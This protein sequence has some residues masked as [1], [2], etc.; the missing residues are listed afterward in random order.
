MVEVADFI[1]APVGP[2]DAARGRR[3]VVRGPLPSTVPA[4]QGWDLADE[5]PGRIDLGGEREA[6]A[7]RRPGQCNRPHRARPGG[8]LGR[9]RRLTGPRGSSRARSSS[10]G[11]RRM[12]ATVEP[13]GERRGHRSRTRPEVSGTR[14]AP[15]PSSAM[16]HRCAT[17]RSPRTDRRPTTATR[18]SAERSCSS[19]TTWRRM[20]SGVNGRR[21]IADSVATPGAGSLVASLRGT[22]RIATL[23]RDAHRS[24]PRLARGRRTRSPTG[25][26]VVALESTLISHG[27][28]Y[29]QNVEVATASEAAVRERGAVPATVALNDGRLLVGLSTPRRSRRSRRR[30]PGRCARSRGPTWRRAIA[31]GGWGATTVAATMIAAEAAGIRVFATGGIGGVHRGALGGRVPAPP[32][33]FDISADLDELARTPVAVVC[34]GPKAILD[35]PRDPRV[36]RDAR[37]AGRVRG[38]RRGPRVL[39]AV[40]GHPGARHVPDLA[41]AAVIPRP[42]GHG[43][44][45][46]VLVCNP[47]PADAASPM[48]SRA[49]RSSR[50][51]A[52][53]TRPGSAGRR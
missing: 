6:R 34:A 44:G 17:Y 52:R 30:P 24:T 49:A 15:P 31:S 9:G 10:S 51:S 5:E 37:R 11:C 12:K 13:S 38:D 18:P 7:I 46:A 41:A 23:A 19:S 2:R 1:P 22:P 39:L 3:A 8:S 29:P 33:T 14:V 27:L 53:R 45:S 50:R 35:V 47:V 16:A 43:L 48:T 36:P 42:R 32:P 20:S 21:A 26:P 25:R 40:V 28:P 4:C